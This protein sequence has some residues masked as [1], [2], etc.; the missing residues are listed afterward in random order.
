MDIE[1]VANDVRE[2]AII[3][4]EGAVLKAIYHKFQVTSNPDLFASRHCHGIPL[5]IKDPH[6][7]DTQLGY[8]AY[9]FLLH[10]QPT[11]VIGNDVSD[12]RQFL[13]QW[14]DWHDHKLPNW[15]KRE[16]VFSH[17]YAR[18]LKGVSGKP[19]GWDYYCDI[20]RHHCKFVKSVTK[21]PLAKKRHGVH[22]AFYDAVEVLVDFFT[23]SSHSS[24]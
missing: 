6:V 17:N 9:K 2:V 18:I 12:L 15:K 20:R 4:L 21:A 3:I 16:S 23:G 24:V 14:T 22:C 10:Q 7:V 13:P 1:G 8:H 19:L 5:L 11:V